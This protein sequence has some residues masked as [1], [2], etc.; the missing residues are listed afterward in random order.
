MFRKSA[1]LQTC[2]DGVKYY[3]QSISLIGLYKAIQQAS[4]LDSL[5]TEHSQIGTIKAAGYNGAR[6]PLHRDIKI[7]AQKS[8]TQDLRLKILAI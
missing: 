3:C 7:Q 2:M 4:Q 5:L 8:T 1:V 6:G